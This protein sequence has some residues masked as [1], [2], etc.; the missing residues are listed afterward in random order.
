MVALTC[1]LTRDAETRTT[2]SGT[3][4]SSL[5]VAFTDRDKVNGEWTD[6]SNFAD[7]TL[8]GNDGVLQYLTKG[9]QIV[10]TGRLRFE[11]WQ[12]KD[13]GT[14]SRLLI[15]ADR[16]QL[17]GGQDDRPASSSNDLPAQAPAPVHS[18]DDLPF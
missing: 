12:A 17:V 6:R 5:R 14:R 3:S 9:R 2:N 10:V 1:R 7:V 4:V 8:W 13:G 16:V 15:V 18:D 11:E